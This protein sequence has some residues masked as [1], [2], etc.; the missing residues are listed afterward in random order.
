MTRRFGEAVLP[1][2]SYTPRPGVYGIIS[3]GD[4]VLLT[5]QSGE[6]QLPGGRID[7]GE[8]PVHALH[9]EAK[10]ETGWK[11]AAPRK[12]GA[13]RRFCYM[14]EYDLWAEK[15][16][17]VYHALAIYPVCPPTEP[18]HIAIMVPR[19]MAADLLAV[20]GDAYFIQRWAQGHFFVN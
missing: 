4:Q 19:D 20:E 13:F 1:K 11:I 14:P 17:H 7:P 18:D 12:L 6:W 2:Q 8:Q 5:S 9:R 15:I 3:H 10:E 16:C